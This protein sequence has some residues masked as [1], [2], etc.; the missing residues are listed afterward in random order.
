[1]RH[2]HT[3]TVLAEEDESVTRQMGCNEGHRFHGMDLYLVPS[4][5]SPTKEHDA[6]A[7]P[8]TEHSWFVM[9]SVCSAFGLRTQLS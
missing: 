9:R 5:K 2:V 3:P 7:S 6:A 1:M 8:P 4:V